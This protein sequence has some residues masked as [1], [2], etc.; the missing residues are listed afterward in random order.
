[1]LKTNKIRISGG[2]FTQKPEIPT[3]GQ[4]WERVK[5]MVGY[6]GIWGIR[7]KEV[8]SVWKGYKHWC[9][10]CMK[11]CSVEVFNV[12]A[13]SRVRRTMIVEIWRVEINHNH[14]CSMCRKLEVHS[15]ST[16]IRIC[17]YLEE[18]VVR[19]I[20]ISDYI[21]FNSF[22]FWELWSRKCLLSFK[23]PEVH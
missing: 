8:C 20:Q 14:E 18:I 4:C 23:C 12:K 3:Y 16:K 17:I 7:W 9:N 22:F 6:K 11:C 21:V 15:V 1:M 10:A 19:I 2:G 13:G 5:G